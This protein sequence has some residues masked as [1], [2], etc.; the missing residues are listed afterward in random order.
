MA[1][2]ASAPHRGTL[3]IISHGTCAILLDGTVRLIIPNVDNYTIVA[4]TF[5]SEQPLRKG[6]RYRLEGVKAPTGPAARIS[7]GANIFLVGVSLQPNAAVFC[8]LDLSI[9]ESFR[10]VRCM[11][12]QKEWFP[13][14][15]ASLRFSSQL[16]LVHVLSYAFDDAASLALLDE[17]NAKFPWKPKFDSATKTVN[18][19]LYSDPKGD[20]LPA[21]PAFTILT[22]LFGQ[23]VPLDLAAVGPFVPPPAIYPEIHG[24]EN[25]LELQDYS[26]SRPQRAAIQPPYDCGKI[27]GITSSSAA[28]ES[29]GSLGSSVSVRAKESGAAATS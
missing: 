1:K 15:P 11:D 29:G 14:P 6:A 21:V 19:H 26:N 8:E 25:L 28:T 4:G 27:V 24:L 18:L 17:A 13:T 20:A 5:L 12:I 7:T 23:E 9:P 16:A 22:K 2:A 3:N 10:S